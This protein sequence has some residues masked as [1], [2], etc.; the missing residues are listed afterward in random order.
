[1]GLRVQ[2][3]LPLGRHLRRL[4]VTSLA[5][6]QDLGYAQNLAQVPPI[7]GLRMAAT[8]KPIPPVLSS[9][10]HP[11][12]S[13]NWHSCAHPACPAILGSS[14]PSCNWHVCA[15]PACPAIVVLSKPLVLLACLRPRGN[16]RPRARGM[17]A[18]QLRL[19][20]EP[21][22]IALCACADSSF[23]P[24]LVYSVLGTSRH[25]AIGPTAVLSLF[26]GSFLGERSQDP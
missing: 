21:A 7:I 14:N 16:A 2:A 13:C 17:N 5:V 3:Q 9:C 19:K 24:P 20:H 18:T 6:P 8:L 25:I 26:L 22:C 11:N 4:A 15:Y 1:M 12:P 10:V 23:L